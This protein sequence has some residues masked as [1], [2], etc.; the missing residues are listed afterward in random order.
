ATQRENGRIVRTRPL[1]P[2]PQVAQHNGTGSIDE[3]ENF[4]CAAP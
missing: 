3:A 4:T 2:Y 1:C